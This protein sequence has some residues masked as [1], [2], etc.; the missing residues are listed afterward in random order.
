VIYHP[1]SGFVRPD[2]TRVF[3]H[4][5][6]RENGAKLLFDIPVLGIDASS[7][8]VRVRTADNTLTADVLIIA[9][10]S[11]LPKLLP[12][13]QLDLSLER[14]VTAWFQPGNAAGLCDGRLP[15]FCLDAD[16]GWYGMP[17][18]E[19][20]V[21]IGHDKHLR[22]QIDPDQSPMTPDAD[23]AA[24]LSRCVRDYFVDINEQPSEM[25]PCIYTLTRD[26]HF[27]IDRHPTYSNV[28]IFSCCS[29][30]GFK[31]A[32]VYGKIAAEL[33]EGTLNSEYSPFRLERGGS[34][35]PRFSD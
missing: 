18:P 35:V 1:A 30:H 34:Q 29:G 10:G 23:D 2:A 16:G 5:M 27:L 6:A 8:T 4:A 25:R 14:R 22:Q 9:A 21:K 7:D 20:R 33:M 26:H 15:V 13:L 3:L 28:L 11:W 24:M 32:P 19:G 17:T 31:Y 12:E